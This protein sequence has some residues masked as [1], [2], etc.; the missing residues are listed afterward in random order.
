MAGRRSVARRGRAAAREE[1]NFCPWRCLFP[2]AWALALPARVLLGTVAAACL[3]ALAVPPGRQRARGLV[4]LRSMSADAGRRGGREGGEEAKKGEDG[5]NQAACDAGVFRRL[6]RKH[7]ST[8]IKRAI[9]PKQ[10]MSPY[11]LWLRDNGFTSGPE[12]FRQWCEIGPDE[13]RD[14]TQR[15]AKLVGER[16]KKWMKT[17]VMPRSAAEQA[18]KE[19]RIAEQERRKKRKEKRNKKHEIPKDEGEKVLTS[20]WEALGAAA[21]PMTAL[22]VARAIG[23]ERA[24]DV[25]P[26]LFR[27]KRDHV[28]LSNEGLSKMPEAIREAAADFPAEATRQEINGASHERF[29]RVNHEL[30]TPLVSGGSWSC[31]LAEP[32]RPLSMMASGSGALRELFAAALRRCGAPSR[33]RPWTLAFGHDEFSPGGALGLGVH[34]IRSGNAWFTPVVVRRSWFRQFMIADLEGHRASLNSSGASCFRPRM[35]HCIALEKTRRG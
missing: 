20:V 15:A 16:F 19:R 30:N 34:N 1:Q 11:T 23:K 31:P 22:D 9:I 7:D 13:E 4:G 28:S 25:N 32:N 8:W 2:R 26:T 21:A 29:E 5:S 14:Y 17:G 35:R 27:L 12:V 6:P 3:R 33:G 10:P 24:K 18:E